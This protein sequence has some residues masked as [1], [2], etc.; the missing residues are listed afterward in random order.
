MLV[1]A[2]IKNLANDGGGALFRYSVRGLVPHSNS[3][4][5]EMQANLERCSMCKLQPHEVYGD[6]PER[7][8]HKHAMATLVYLRQPLSKEESRQAD[9]MIK[10]IVDAGD[11]TGGGEAALDLVRD[12]VSPPQA[13]VHRGRDDVDRSILDN[14]ELAVQS[15]LPA[16]PLGVNCE[17]LDVLGGGVLK[18][19]WLWVES[20]TH[21]W[22]RQWCVLWPATAHPQH[23]QFLFCFKDRRAIAPDSVMQLLVPVVRQ[24][25]IFVST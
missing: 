3:G 7:M 11:L 17:L 20:S 2:L 1:V 12:F 13:S 19:G 23:G 10:Q 21:K 14:A 4:A 24:C 8:V 22:A 18:D 6:K 25:L 16:L 5:A 9:T 15:V